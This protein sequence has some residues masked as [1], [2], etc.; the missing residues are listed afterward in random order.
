MYTIYNLHNEGFQERKNVVL[1]GV[2]GS[3]KSTLAERFSHLRYHV[4]HCPYQPSYEDM[5]EH[6]RT[7]LQQVPHPVIL[8][9]SFIAEM[10]YG[11]VLRGSSRLSSHEFEELLRL[12]AAKNFVVFYLREKSSILRERLSQT[13]HA[14]HMV[15]QHLP[16]L[17][18]AYDHCMEL[19]TACVPTYTICPTD[20]PP[21]RMLDQLILLLS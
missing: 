2:D 7:F 14:H 12:L 9:R 6:Y 4:I 19:V 3:G 17:I 18:T 8:D 15:L 20:L 1:E 11:P 10:V 21:E 5:Y 13:L 16:K